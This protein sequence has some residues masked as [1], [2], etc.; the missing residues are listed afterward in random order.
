MKKSTA[1]LVVALLALLMMPSMSIAAENTGPPAIVDNQQLMLQFSA[2]NYAYSTIVIENIRAAANSSAE[3]AGTGSVLDE[4]T[5][6]TAVEGT[7]GRIA[8]FEKSE[9]A[10]TLTEDGL[11]FVNRTTSGD[12]FY[13][14]DPGRF[15]ALTNSNT[16]SEGLTD[17]VAY[18]LPAR[19][20]PMFVALMNNGL[21]SS[22]HYDTIGRDASGVFARSTNG[23]HFPVRTG[24]GTAMTAT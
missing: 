3:L 4:S 9:F 11:T 10:N 22:K 1:F 12:D 5:T 19:A 20:A 15:E 24:S 8:S 23:G 21:A 16:V 2:K 17:V 14:K 6:A 18:G 7:A 13:C